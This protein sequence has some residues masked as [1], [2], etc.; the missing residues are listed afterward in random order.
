MR[1]IHLYLAV[2]FLL[3]IAAGATLWNAGVLARAAG[4]WALLGAFVAV[5]LGLL[6]ALAFARQPAVSRE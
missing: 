5:A 4:I 2:Y 3:L 6:L 1:F